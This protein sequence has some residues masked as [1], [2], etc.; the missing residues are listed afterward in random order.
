MKTRSLE[1][2]RKGLVPLTRVERE[3]QR[4]LAGEAKGRGR[5]KR[6]RIGGFMR[7][8]VIIRLLLV[9]EGV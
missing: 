9:T 2:L 5:E 8:Y 7:N 1:D 6:W 3:R 4:C